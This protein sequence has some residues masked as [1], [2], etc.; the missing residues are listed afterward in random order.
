MRPDDDVEGAGACLY[1]ALRSN[2]LTK[3]P[4]YDRTTI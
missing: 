4:T 2:D 3:P 1:A